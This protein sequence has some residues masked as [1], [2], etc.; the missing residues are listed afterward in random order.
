M[1]SLIWDA[2][3]L[4]CFGVVVFFS[5]CMCCVFMSCVHAVAVLNAAFCI[6]WCL[7][8]FVEDVR[9]NHVDYAHSMVWCLK[10]ASVLSGLSMRLLSVDHVCMAVCMLWLRSCCRMLIVDVMVMSAAYELSCSSTGGCGMYDVHLLRSVGERT[11]P[12]GTPLLNWRC[13]DMCYL[14]GMYVLLHCM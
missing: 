7:L 11:P 2:C 13:V 4:R 6:V 3:S 10:C 14:S 12:L 8:K 5:S 9:G 1:F